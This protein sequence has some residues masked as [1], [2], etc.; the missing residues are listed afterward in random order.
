MNNFFD[1]S[2]TRSDGTKPYENYNV[3]VHYIS[4]NFYLFSNFKKTYLEAQEAQKN[5]APKI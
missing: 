1:K 2:Y 3:K 5:N 4:L